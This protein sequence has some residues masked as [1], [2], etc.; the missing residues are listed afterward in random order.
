MEYNE[1]I[2]RAQ[3]ASVDAPDTDAILAGMRR[4][5]RRRQRQRQTVLSTLIV[6]AV[7]SSA[8]LMQP[9]YDKADSL[10]LAEVVSRRIDTPPTNMPA[11]LVGYRNSI[12]NR[13]IYTLL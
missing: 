8:Y 3:Q 6:L 12:H 4:T 9:R 11:P 1:L 2:T 5:M 7:T 10:T 13:Q